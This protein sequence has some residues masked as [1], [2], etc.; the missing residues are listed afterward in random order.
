MLARLHRLLTLGQTDATPPRLSR[1]LRMTNALALIGLVLTLVSAPVDAYGATPTAVVIDL[2]GGIA[3]AAP[4]L[5]GARGYF[6]ASRISLM[7]IANATILLGVLQVGGGPGT[8]SVCFP[9]VLLPFLLFELRER[10]WLV[11]FVTIPIVGYFATGNL[12]PPH[13]GFA[14]DIYRIYAPLLSFTMI[15][16]G[17][18]VFVVVE[19]DA[20]ARLVQARARAAHAAQLA[21]L[22][23][24]ASGIAHEIRNPLAAI[25]LA[26]TEVAAPPGQTEQVAQ[27]GQ[28]IQRIVMRA[29]SIIETLR[30]LARD[31]SNDPFVTTPVKRIVSDTLELCSKRIAEKGIELTVNPIPDGLQVECRPVQLSQ[32]LMNLLTNAYDAVGGTADAW[33]RVDATSD[34]THLEMAVTNSGDAIREDLRQRI[35]EPFFTTKSA[36]RG[37][38]LGLSLCTSIVAA[39][40]GTIALDASSA[41]TRFVVRVP[42]VQ[43]VLAAAS[44]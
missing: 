38:G 13:E 12:G 18:I 34:G 3:F 2:V 22:G 39:H 11:L 44:V 25:H 43:T 14:T 36:D 23:E 8:R 41:N 27:L 42:L 1:Q 7:L 24:M 26:A 40:R 32:V 35:F 9:L 28:R 29:S 31:A 19:R 15:V 4:L 5:L 6:N 21:S 30:S 16:T 37:T 17:C 33:V 20:D 10:G